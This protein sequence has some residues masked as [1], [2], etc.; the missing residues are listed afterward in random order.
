MAKD[1]FRIAV[2]GAGETGTPLLTQLLDAPFVEILGV[3]D[4]DAEAPGM[5]LARAR[6]VATTT[7]FMDLARLGE[8]VDVLIDVTGV[9][10][11]REA[12]RQ[13]MQDS[14]NTHTLIVHE[15][16]VQLMLSLLS[17]RLVQLKHEVEEY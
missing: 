3:A 6:G 14:G 17:G 1:I 5:R 16:V 4:L 2:I 11:V 13:H 15:M 12:L 8:A 7:D 10:K 9:P